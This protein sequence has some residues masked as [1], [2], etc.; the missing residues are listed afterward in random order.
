MPR[1]RRRMLS[2]ARRSAQALPRSLLVLR[3]R[4]HRPHRRSS[5]QRARRSMLRIQRSSAQAL[6]RLMLVLHQRPGR[7]RSSERLSPER[8]RMLRFARRGGQALCCASFTDTTAAA[9]TDP[10]TSANANS[11][12]E[13]AYSWCSSDTD[14]AHSENANS[15][16][17]AANGDNY[18]SQCNLDT[19][20][21]I[22]T[23]PDA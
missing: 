10:A 5:M 4:S 22:K 21:V 7:S 23:Y 15:P 19:S 2:N 18:S 17:K 16:A 11:A 14:S 6:R 3:R 20:Q 12:A 9:N 13:H 8:W 1:T